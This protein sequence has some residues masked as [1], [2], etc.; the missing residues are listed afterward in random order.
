MCLDK[1]MAGDDERQTV[2]IALN[3]T[4]N[5]SSSSWYTGSCWA[6]E[7]MNSEVL[8]GF[9]VIRRRRSSLR[10]SCTALMICPWVKP[11][12]NFARQLMFSKLVI[13]PPFCRMVC[14]HSTVH[15]HPEKGR[16]P[17][18]CI[19]QSRRNISAF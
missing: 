4:L 12:D 10:T 11:S 18:T 2:N 16:M 7:V 8:S 19:K 1:D 5:V 17:K 9:L 14:F 3:V 15:Q 13:I 6:R